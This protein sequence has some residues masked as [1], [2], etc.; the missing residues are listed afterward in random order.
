MARISNSSS[1]FSIGVSSRS[2]SASSA[3]SSSAISARACTFSGGGLQFLVGLEQAV[4]R[5]E[6]S[7]DLLGLF[8]VVPEVGLAH[9]GVELFAL[10][11][12]AG[13]VKES[14]AAGSDGSSTSSVRRRRSAF[15]AF[16]NSGKGEPGRVNGR[17]FEYPTNKQVDGTT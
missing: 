14:P 16:L 6:L 4:E 9:L 3:A 10:G 13:D 15:I 12:F 17:R 1:A 2:S 5:L 11:L 7:D 8:G